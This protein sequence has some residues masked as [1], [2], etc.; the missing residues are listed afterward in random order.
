[1]FIQPNKVSSSFMDPQKIVDSFGIDS[2][3][4]VADFG[5]GAGYF[6]IP[7]AKA[8][9]SKGK[10]FAVDILPSALEV[11]DKK[12]KM[13]NLI[14][15]ELVQADLEKENSTKIIDS[16]VDF[17]VISNLLFQLENKANIFREAKRV[18]K[19]GGKLIVIDW[20]GGKIVLGPPEENRVTEDQVQIAA[21]ISGFKQIKQWHPDAYHYGFIFIK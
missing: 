15:I 16:S 2:G 6:V 12:A 4:I 20:A 13:E 18:L 11:I 9:K 8:V 17:V 3:S 7:L 14:N 19:S 10:I 21:T 1:M 5:S